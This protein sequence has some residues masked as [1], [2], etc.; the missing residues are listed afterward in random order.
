MHH[1]FPGDN[2]FTSFERRRGL[3]IGDLMSQFSGNVYLDCLARFSTEVLHL[4]CLRLYPR[5]AFVASTDAPSA[6]L[7]FVFLPGRHRV[8][9]PA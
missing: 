2:L 8:P 7:G 3:P 1:H 9:A 4:P 6:F 5:K